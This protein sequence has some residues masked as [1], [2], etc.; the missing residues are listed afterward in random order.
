MACLLPLDAVTV[1]TVAAT[2]ALRIM[3]FDIY[4]NSVVGPLVLLGLGS[5]VGVLGY[6]VVGLAGATV[7][8]TLVMC[9]L[10][11]HFFRSRFRL[12]P[13]LRYLFHG[14]TWRHLTSFSFAIMLLEL[15]GNLLLRLDILMLAAYASAADI[16]IYSIAR[17]VS[18]AALKVP[19]SFDP[20]FSPIASEL[21]HRKSYGELGQ[22]LAAVARWSL[23]V[24][25][26]VFAVLLLAGRSIL[27]LLG[28]DTTSAAGAMSVLCLGMMLFSLFIPSEQLLIMSGRQYL[29]LVD[30]VAWVAM[31]YLLNLWLIPRYGIMGAAIST[32]VAMNAINAVRLVQVYVIYR[33]HPL[34]V[35]LLKP[36]VA[37]CAGVAVAWLAGRWLP[38]GLGW[39]D[40]VRCLVFL[41]VYGGL[42]WT[43]GLEPHDRVLLQRGLRRFRRRRRERL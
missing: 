41:A 11:V 10:G 39:P 29:G 30:T 32:A 3:R 26:V 6:G 2:R 28:P 15:L 13:C 1:L 42:L 25:F 35:S 27:S 34:H 7:A 40:G 20:I 24:N 4:V 21:S 9:V 8:M 22:R 14:P 19:Q 33:C 18:S 16:G 12:R 23:T 37:G 5:L 17:R 31:N 36:L 43:L 38:A